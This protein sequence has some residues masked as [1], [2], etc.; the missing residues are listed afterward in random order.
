MT[1]QEK[2]KAMRD[3]L[4]RLQERNNKLEASM[5]EMHQR[6]SQKD[7]VHI[8]LRSLLHLFWPVRSKS[9]RQEPDRNSTQAI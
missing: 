4:Q 6:M 2:Y 7:E 9:S 8:S 3:Q 5:T 1:N